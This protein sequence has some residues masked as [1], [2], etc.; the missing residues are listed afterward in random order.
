MDITDTAL[1]LAEPDSPTL[2]R[3]L[4]DIEALKGKTG[5]NTN[6]PHTI[7]QQMDILR[8]LIAAAHCANPQEKSPSARVTVACDAWQNATSHAL[9]T[10]AH[11]EMCDGPTKRHAWR[12]VKEA[13]NDL[14]VALVSNRN[15]ADGTTEE[16]GLLH[17]ACE[18]A[19]SMYV[20]ARTSGRDITCELTELEGGKQSNL[21]PY[22]SEKDEL[23]QSLMRV[24]KNADGIPLNRYTIDALKGQPQRFSKENMRTVATSKDGL[25]HIQYNVAIDRLDTANQLTNYLKEAFFSQ[26]PDNAL[27]N[28]ALTNL[29]NFCYSAHI[30][31]TFFGLPLIEP[32]KSSK[33]ALNQAR[34]RLITLQPPQ[35][36]LLSDATLSLANS[37][38]TRETLWENVQQDLC[39]A[40]REKAQNLT[41]QALGKE[42]YVTGSNALD[43]VIGQVVELTQAAL[44]QS[45][46]A[47][48]A[49]G[50]TVRVEETNRGR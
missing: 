24:W 13:S 26:L 44:L 8:Q 48:Q 23:P 14:R 2:Q 12:C 34:N 15:A 38:C 35:L 4:G 6:A 18:L 25:P 7:T 11:E 30:V 40:L 22:D 37:Q 27:A 36:A 29:L 43:I 19:E 39:F 10:L 1:S 33:A 32:Q 3:L 5:N 20:I 9:E 28:K 45:A 50:P 41:V 17:R 42:D 16:K 49:A 46:N 31:T 21:R 47:L